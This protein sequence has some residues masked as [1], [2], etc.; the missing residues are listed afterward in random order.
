MA[1]TEV[2]NAA[3]EGRF[4]WCGAG[5]WGARVGG[6]G[7]R[8]WAG[9]SKGPSPRRHRPPD[10]HLTR[11][12]ARLGAAAHRLLP[13]AR[14]FATAARHFFVLE[15]TRVSWEVSNQSG[16]AQCGSLGGLGQPWNTWPTHP[17]PF[18]PRR[19]PFHCIIP[20]QGSRSSSMAP[21]KTAGEWR[22]RGGLPSSLGATPRTN[23][24]VRHRNSRGSSHGSSC[25][26]NTSA[27]SGIQ[28]PPPRRPAPAAAALMASAALLPHRHGVVACSAK[29]VPKVKAATNG[30]GKKK[31]TTRVSTLSCRFGLRTGAPHAPKRLILPN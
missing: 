6:R 11:L 30:E 29:K 12:Q 14:C 7:S 22:L 23:P 3:R 27:T 20:V 18:L 26:S 8:G 4:G 5:R 15:S 9:G 21:K 28:S 24:M 2:Q 19:S 25:C 31:K 13:P 10:H 16:S 1:A 17:P